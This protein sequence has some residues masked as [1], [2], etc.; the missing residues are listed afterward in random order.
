MGNETERRRMFHQ[1]V[2]QISAT[3]YMNEIA[4]RVGADQKNA[5]QRRVREANYIQ[6][7]VRALHLHRRACDVRPTL[8]VQT[9]QAF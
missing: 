5:I 8:T 4:R 9:Y 1:T 2:Y 3:S 7:G 6:A